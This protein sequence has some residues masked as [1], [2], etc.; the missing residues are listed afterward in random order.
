VDPPLELRKLSF[1]VGPSTLE[2][3]N[4]RSGMVSIAGMDYLPLAPS[5]LPRCFQM[6]VESLPSLDD[7]YDRAIHVFLFMAR[8]Q[9]FFDVNKRMGRF[10]MNRK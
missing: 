1:K 7:V 5:E 8:T 3:G 9:F 10:M 4:L 2:W 6:F